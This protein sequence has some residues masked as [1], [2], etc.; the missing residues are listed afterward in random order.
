MNK[1]QMIGAVVAM[2]AAG[3]LAANTSLAD[4]H[5]K[6]GEKK[7]DK[8]TMKCL[9]GNACSGK[10]A[11]SAADGSSSCA[12][13]NSCK[14]KGWTTVGSE[15]ECTKAGGKVAKDEKKEAPKAE[16]KKS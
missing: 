2:A 14:G 4:H 8:K 15:E 12:G 3:V 16:E 11:C 6:A 10:G 9:G 13:K 5:E 1:R 7:A